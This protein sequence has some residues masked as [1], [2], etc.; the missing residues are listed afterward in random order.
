MRRIKS[1]LHVGQDRARQIHD[2][3]TAVATAPRAARR[4]DRMTTDP[5]GPG[6]EPEDTGNPPEDTDDDV[7]EGEVIAF[8]GATA[9][10]GRRP[11]PRPARRDARASSPTT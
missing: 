2:H 10:A 11:A 9:P 7:L 4:E 6:Q 3:L 8:P 1:E 5:A